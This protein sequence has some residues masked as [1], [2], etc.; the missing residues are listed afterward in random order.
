MNPSTAVSVMIT[1]T[2]R[3]T[4]AIVPAISPMLEK[5]VT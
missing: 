5:A 4:A 1:V 2:I 3:A